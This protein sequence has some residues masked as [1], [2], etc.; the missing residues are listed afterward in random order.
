LPYLALLVVLIAIVDM[1]YD[2]L[3]NASRSMK[4]IGFIVS[5]TL[6]VVIK[7]KTLL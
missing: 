1:G 2:S 3:A 5:Y 4:R 6:N 7:V